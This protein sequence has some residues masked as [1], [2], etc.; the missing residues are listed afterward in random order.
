MARHAPCICQFQ[1]SVTGR[2][3]L[4]ISATISTQPARFDA[5]PAAADAGVGASGAPGERA[6]RG[7][8]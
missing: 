6:E 3:S 8:T 5:E 1:M 7:P 4:R 2:G